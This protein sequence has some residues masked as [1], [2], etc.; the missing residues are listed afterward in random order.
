MTQ[1][2]V[3][4]S[5]AELAELLP[6]GRVRLLDVRWRLGG[7]AGHPQYLEGHIPGAVYADLDTDLAAPGAPGE[8]RHPLPDVAD[9]QAAARR[10]GINAGDTVVAYDDN[11]NLAAARARWLL[12]WAGLTDVRLLDG[13][14]PAWL[15]AGQPVASGEERPEPGDVVLA[16]GALP[17]V[18][19]DGAAALVAGGGVLLDARASGRYQGELNNIDPRL[20][21]IPGAVSAPTTDNL[22]ADGRFRDGKELAERFAALGVTPGATVGVYCGSGVTAAHEIAALELAGI[23]G[24]VLY[25]GSWS[26]WAT[27]PDRPVVAGAEPY[28]P[29]LVRPEEAARRVAAGA[30]LVDVRSAPRRESDGAIPGA[31]IGDRTKVA[32]EFGS[33]PRERPIVVI[34]GSVDGSRAV[35]EELLGLGFT[36]V[37]HVEGGYPAWAAAG[38]PT[39]R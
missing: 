19:P 35:A 6:A 10:W 7:P 23:D 31:I 8:G 37:V 34:C 9:L 5:V 3:L 38:L 2:P 12:R 17:A 28:G 15:A 16:A 30:V 25:P 13:G 18:G 1:S 33:T 32:E 36:D 26:Q 29:P 11:G 21:H 27:L 22:T 14:L 4:V 39:T 20:G 24:A